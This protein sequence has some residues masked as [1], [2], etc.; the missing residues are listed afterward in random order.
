MEGTRANAWRFLA[1]V[2][3]AIPGTETVSMLEIAPELTYRFENGACILNASV[4]PNEVN[5]AVAPL[6]DAD[7]RALESA[8]KHASQLPEV[9]EV[10]RLEKQIDDTLRER[11]ELMLAGHAAV[12]QSKRSLECGDGPSQ[13]ERAGAEAER[14]I[15]VLDARLTHLTKLLATSERMAI[16]STRMALESIHGALVAF[17]HR[18]RRADAL[19]RLK[20]TLKPILVELASIDQTEANLYDP[21]T[22]GP[23]SWVAV[24]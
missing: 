23:P 8:A 7:A 16:R 14:Q 12:E 1:V 10:Q 6:L 24:E 19:E 9:L 11:A 2:R 22:G 5:Q 4:D 18:S 13:H 3:D 21:E 15:E 17:S 20:G